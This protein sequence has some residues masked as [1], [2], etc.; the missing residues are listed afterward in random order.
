[1]IWGVFVATSVP[2]LQHHL[3]MPPITFGS[4]VVKPDL[5]WATGNIVTG[6]GKQFGVA[7]IYG[8]VDFSAGALLDI[9]WATG[10]IVMDKQLGSVYSRC[11]QECRVF[12]WYFSG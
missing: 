1:M 6:E 10:N 2:S 9:T 8:N 11:L 7:C 4:V 12:S 3:V 5:T